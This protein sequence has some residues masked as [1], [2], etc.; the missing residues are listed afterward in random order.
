[1]FIDLG[2]FEGDV[3]FDDPS[4]S[5]GN[6]EGINITMSLETKKIT[7]KT[8]NAAMTTS[9]DGDISNFTICDKACCSFNIKSFLCRSTIVFHKN[10]KISN[11]LT[12]NFLLFPVTSSLS[13]PENVLLLV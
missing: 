9:F 7:S 5:E 10:R 11:V 8:S 13:T 4:D 12:I 1:M 6:S 2:V 3:Y